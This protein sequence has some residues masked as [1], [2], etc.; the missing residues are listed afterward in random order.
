MRK[1][2]LVFPD[3]MSMT[4]FL[5]TNKMSKTI[6]NSVTKELKA[7]MTDKV[8][9]IACKDYGAKV[10]EVIIVTHF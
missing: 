10:K 3:V 9:A 6:T 5:L 4:E 1:V 8:L 2:I 7:I